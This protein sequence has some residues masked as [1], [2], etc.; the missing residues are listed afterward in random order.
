MCPGWTI[1]N[2]M[3]ILKWI[4]MMLFIIATAVL[5]F[6][7]AAGVFAGVILACNVIPWLLW[8]QVVSPTFGWPHATFWQVFFICWA[9]SIVGRLLFGSRSK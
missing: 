1:T 8:N 9:M 6:L 4:L 2:R 7:L 3:K 5:P